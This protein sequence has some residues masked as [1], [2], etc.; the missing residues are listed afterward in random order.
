MDI[1]RFIIFLSVSSVINRRFIIY[2]EGFLDS[3][4]FRT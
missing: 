1:R 4:Q 2:I 3:K